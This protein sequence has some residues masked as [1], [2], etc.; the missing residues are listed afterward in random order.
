MMHQISL[1]FA[2]YIMM[3]WLVLGLP[4]WSYW[5]H[6]RFE[7]A[8]TAGDAG[9]LRNS[10]LK[11]LYMLWGP[12]LCIVGFWF[13]SGRAFEALGLSIT[14]T[15][16]GAIGLGVA[17]LLTALLS[18]QVYQAK[19]NKDVAAKF[20]KEL[21][22]SPSVEKILPKTEADYRLFKGL[23]ITAGLTEEILFR[24]YLIWALSF[25]MESWLAAL[26]SLAAFVLAHL[27][28]G[29]TEAIVKVT[30][31]GGA[32]TLLYLLSGSL[33]PAIILHAVIDLTSGA[34]CWHARRTSA[35]AA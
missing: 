8:L 2:D 14:P 23:S 12:T 32:L 16:S 35:Q 10:Y 25:W 9:V 7:R 24:G 28:Q 17:L 5:D 22:R 20:M 15:L 29:T 13:A 30:I 33:V 34:T 11:T 6:K 31:T 4:V 18:A 1:G 21:A 3:F 26:L 19:N 27:Y